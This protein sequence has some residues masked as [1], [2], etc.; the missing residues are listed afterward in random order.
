MLHRLLLLIA[1]LA[2]GCAPASGSSTP[3][4]ANAELARATLLDL[5]GKPTNLTQVAAGKVVV[6]SLWAPWCEGCR[7]EEPALLRLAALAKD[8]GDFV[9]VSVAI[10]ASADE[11]KSAA[12]PYVRLLDTGPFA[13][14]GKRRVPATL[15]LDRTGQQVFEG[16]AL[17]RD[18]L[19]ALTQVLGH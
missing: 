10:D 11:V 2:L 16:G 3:S 15:V 9:L 6:V 18:A 7:T 1:F 12:V 17:D 8:R 14:L 13:R 4:A 5:D 19:D